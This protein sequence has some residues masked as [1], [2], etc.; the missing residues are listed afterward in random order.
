MS[1]AIQMI[2]ESR[3][4]DGHLRSKSMRNSSK[5]ILSV[6][7]EISHYLERLWDR[8]TGS[9]HIERIT[10]GQKQ[11]SQ[12]ENKEK[13]HLRQSHRYRIHHRPVYVEY[14]KTR[15]SP[16][17][18]LQSKRLSEWKTQGNTNL[19]ILAR[20]SPLPVANRLFVGLGATEITGW[21][22]R[23]ER[24]QIEEAQITHLS[25][26][27]LEASSVQ[28]QCS[29]PRTERLCPWIHS[30]SNV[31]R[32]SGKHWERNP[33]LKQLA[34]TKFHMWQKVNIN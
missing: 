6:A 3:S 19:Q 18:T 5:P 22:V 28:F 9:W 21:N 2:I 24:P 17:R 7:R 23:M 25:S 8:T 34:H 26:C 15:V 32:E 16:R 13:P 33:E 27:D 1:R 4:R 11:T 31:R 10:P 30:W 12:S 29:D 14:L 20:M